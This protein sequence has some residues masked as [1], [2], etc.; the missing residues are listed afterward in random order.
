MP[1]RNPKV[2]DRVIY[3]KDKHSGSPGQRAR[4]VSAAAKGDGYS[5]IVEKYWVVK[6]IQQDGMLLLKTRRGKEHLIA[7]DDPS[8]RAATLLEKLLLRNRFPKLDE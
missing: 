3:A 6:A 5:Y 4:D 7:V 8:L 2:G 1:I